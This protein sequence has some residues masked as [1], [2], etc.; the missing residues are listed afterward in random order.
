M[1][2]DAEKNR[3]LVALDGAQG[4]G[5][6]ESAERAPPRS[7]VRSLLDRIRTGQT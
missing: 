3:T 6:G 2:A 4:E 7:F 1:R 5:S